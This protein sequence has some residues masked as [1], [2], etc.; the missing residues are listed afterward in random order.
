MSNHADI[1]IR[2]LLYPKVKDSTFKD[3]TFT[4]PVNCGM[5]SIYFFRYVRLI[6]QF[7]REHAGHFV[8]KVNR[9]FSYRQFTHRAVLLKRVH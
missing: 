8:Y 6:F 5:N 4:L 3:S 7:I 9:L 1:F 2:I